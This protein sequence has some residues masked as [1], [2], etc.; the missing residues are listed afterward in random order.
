MDNVNFTKD[1]ITINGK[2]I[3]VEVGSIVQEKLKFYP[4]NPRIYSIIYSGEKLLTQKEIEERLSEKDYVNVLVQSI[5]ANG[6]LTDPVIVK[7]GSFEVLEGNSRLAAYRILSKKDPIKWGK[8][9]C[10]VLP[11]EISEDLIFTLLGEYHIIGRKD[12]QPYEQAGYLY[13]RHKLQKVPSEI[14]QKE[15]GLK[16][17]EIEH[18][19]EVYSFMLEQKDTDVNRWSYYE[20]YLKSNYI[21]KIREENPKFDELI[22]KKIKTGEISKAIDVREKLV[23][24]AKASAK[25]IKQFISGKI[26]F[27]EAYARAI[28]GGAGNMIFEKLHRF[29]DWLANSA[30]EDEIQDNDEQLT[31]K[32]LFELKKIEK[33]VE[34]ILSK[35]KDNQ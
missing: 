27:E 17:G 23:P 32:C 35:F 25:T 2:E 7:G 3:P 34:D 11:E 24:I 9:K 15:L 29:R 6:G 18:L 33:R 22:V 16:K 26:D 14:M 30:V 21:K 10:K 28:A 8:I 13:R 20:E 12:W 31:K 5:E 1:S 4:E 19:I